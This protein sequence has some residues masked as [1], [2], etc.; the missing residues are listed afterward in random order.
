M[1]G[2]RSAIFRV[3]NPDTKPVEKVSHV[4]FD[5]SFLMASATTDT[6]YWLSEATSDQ[7]TGE[8]DAGE[9]VNEH[10]DP[11]VIT[12][13]TSELVPER[14]TGDTGD[15]GEETSYMEHLEEP[16]QVEVLPV[17]P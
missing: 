6:C 12:E 13:H 7:P 11:A 17:G 4:N 10:L 16:S 15:V 2:A 5:E 1:R 8:S 14:E 3:W 9:E